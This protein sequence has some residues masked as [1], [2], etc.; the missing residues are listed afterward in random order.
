MAFNAADYHPD[1]RSISRQIREQ[2]DQRCEWCGVRNGAVGARDLAGVWHDEAD[3]DRMNAS[4]GEVLF[5]E[6]PAL[7]RVVLTVHHQCRDDGCDRRTCHD[8][9]HVVA[10]CQKHHLDADR[11]HHLAAAARTRQRRRQERIAATGQLM[12][13]GATAIAL[14]ADAEEPA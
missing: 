13:E 1:W 12:L 14:D 8:P 10:L 6:Y 9:A 2:A 7:V 11:P 3:L 4:L 5:G